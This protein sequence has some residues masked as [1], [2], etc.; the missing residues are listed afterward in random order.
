MATDTRN[1]SIT[2]VREGDQIVEGR[3]SLEVREVEHSACSSRGTHI[4]GRMC[5]DQ[6]SMVKVQRKL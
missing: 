4:N 6:I 5:Y 3:K 2:D 1:M